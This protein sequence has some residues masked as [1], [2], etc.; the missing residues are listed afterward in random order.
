MLLNSFSKVSNLRKV[1][2]KKLANVISLKSNY[3][4]YNVKK[5][6]SVI[7]LYRNFKETTYITN[8]LL[9]NISELFLN[10]IN[11][12]WVIKY[13]PSNFIKYIT[14]TN[15]NAYSILYLRKNKVFNKGRYSRN[16]QYYRTGVY[17]CLYLNIIAVIGIYFWFYRFTMNFGYLWWLLFF[18]IFSFIAPKTIKYRLYNPLTLI[19]S[20]WKDLLWLALLIHSLNSKIIKILISVYTFIRIYF[21]NFFFFKNIS[22]VKKTSF[23]FIFYSNCEKIICNIL[24]IN[25]SSSIYSWEYNHINYYKSSTNNSLIFIERF[26][27]TLI[28]NFSFIGK[29]K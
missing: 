18:F 16:R 11:L 22:I 4:F 12:N 21:Y 26:K 15:L 8:K 13:S 24:N 10:K 2:L 28:Q 1:N 20:L 23:L 29:F 3:T 6:N 19:S 27:Y 5:N 17:W 14:S 7:L 25:N 9:V